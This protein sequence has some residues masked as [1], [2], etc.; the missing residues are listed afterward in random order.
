[1][2]RIE[3]GKWCTSRDGELY[4][5]DDYNTK[6]EAIEGGKLDYEYTTFYVGKV[7]ALEFEESDI[8]ISEDAFESLANT[9]SEDCGEVAEEWDATNEEL[10]ELDE[11]LSKT[12]IE[13]VNKNN[14]HPK[15]FG[16]NDDCRIEL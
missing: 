3:T 7:V 14:L 13:W 2:K 16:I 9:L 1:M 12:V 15:C 5:P 4:N 6:E 8:Y 10:E 11:M